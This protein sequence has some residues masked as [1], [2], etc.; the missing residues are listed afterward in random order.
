MRAAV[1]YV[2]HAGLARFL[3]CSGVFLRAGQ[4]PARRK[5]EMELVEWNDCGGAALAWDKQC[6]AV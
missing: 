2:E 3:L 4:V 1:A 5:N 6:F